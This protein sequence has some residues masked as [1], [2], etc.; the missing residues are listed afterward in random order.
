MSDPDTV[1]FDS[2]ASWSEPALEADRCPRVAGPSESSGF[3][4]PDT[5]QSFSV[6]TPTNDQSDDSYYPPETFQS[7]SVATPTS[8]YSHEGTFVDACEV[9]DGE[10][11][12]A[13]M[14]D[15]GVRKV[16]GYPAS[17]LQL[18]YKLEEFQQL[19][20]SPASSHAGV[21]ALLPEDVTSASGGSLS[22]AAPCIDWYDELDQGNCSSHFFWLEMFYDH[23][24]GSQS[25]SLHQGGR[26]ANYSVNPGRQR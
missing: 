15:D 1:H 4:Q 13:S 7:F 12:V 21:Y 5:F 19:E 24:R 20:L 11:M 17:A 3:Y 18:L 22:Q 9:A 2:S 8:S 23:H 26:H 16:W 25:S 14:I 6:A 10:D